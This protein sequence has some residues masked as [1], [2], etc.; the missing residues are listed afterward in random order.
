MLDH[1]AH[2][3]AGVAVTFPSD[4]GDVDA[5]ATAV[6][7]TAARLTRRVSGRAAGTG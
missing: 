5:I 2:P 6:T 7:R 4:V 3:V 1:N